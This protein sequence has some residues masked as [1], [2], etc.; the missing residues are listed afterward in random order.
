VSPESIPDARVDDL[1]LNREE[2]RV[3]WRRRLAEL[4]AARLTS[5]RS[6]LKQL[7]VIDADGALISRELPMLPDSDATLETG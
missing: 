3:E 6:R 5:A 7:G 2:D 1:D 4:A